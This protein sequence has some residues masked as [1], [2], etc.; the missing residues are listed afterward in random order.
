M[1]IKLPQYTIHTGAQADNPYKKFMLAFWVIVSLCLG[2]FGRMIYEQSNVATLQ[3]RNEVL[4]VLNSDYQDKLVQ[5]DTQITVLKTENKV[6]QEAITILRKDYKESIEKQNELNTD[7]SFYQR[8][9][10][11]DAENK[12]LRVF[13]NQ[14]TQLSDGS[15]NLNIVLVQK[16]ERAREVSGTI[17]VELLGESNEEKTSI[18]LNKKETSQYKFKYFQNI[19]LTFSLPEGFKA[20]QL[21]VK[22]NPSTKKAK[23]VTQTSDWITLTQQE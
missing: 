8:L 23:S 11:P 6:K 5:K 4:E 20:E 7:I 15:Y 19:S 9:L 16:I 1:S 12:G 3:E 13:E 18:L 10:S 14:L 2:Y 17:K 22:L 21:V